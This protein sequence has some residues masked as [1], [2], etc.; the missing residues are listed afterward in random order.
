MA[1]PAKALPSTT[2]TFTT[3]AAPKVT[4]R[5]P[6]SAANSIAVASNISTTFSEAVTGVA[7]T[8]FTLKNTV[9]GVAVPSAVSY[10]TTTRVATLNPT[11]NLVA[12]TRYTA[13]LTGG[14][15][16]IR[17]SQGTGLAT[18]SWTFTTGPAPVVSARVPAVNATAVRRANNITVN[19]SESVLGVGTPTLNLRNATTGVVVAATVTRNGTTNQWIVNPTASLAANT[20]YTVRVNG[21]ATLIRDAAINPLVST[22]WTF[23][24]G[25]S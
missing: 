15:A 24:T 7:A 1:T 3:T 13:V 5:T 16:A 20:R 8:T 4:V 14:S 9:T 12:D 18:H 25:A 11:A 17:D 19:F 22:S 2:W 21:G 10:N 23:T 6:A